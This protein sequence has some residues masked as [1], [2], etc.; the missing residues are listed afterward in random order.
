[1]V[2][3]LETRTGADAYHWHGLKRGGDRRNPYVVLQFTLEGEGAYRAGGVEQR[4]VAGSVL[5]AVVPSDHAYYLPARSGEWTFFWFITS[6]TYFVQRA[7]R[8]IERAGA[9]IEAGLHADAFKDAAGLVVDLCIGRFASPASE[10][11]WEGRLLAVMCRLDEAASAALYP[12]GPRERLLTAVRQTV[13]ADFLRPPAVEAIAEELGMSRTAFSHRF[14]LATGRTPLE[15]ITELR[16]AEVRRMLTV[17]D[18]PLKAIATATGYADANHLCK[19]F[20]RHHRMS[21]GRFRQQVR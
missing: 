3:G 12:A 2:C 8:R 20:R 5:T 17:T 14:R 9:V 1:M 6:H 16:L 11:A 7:I 19:A 13:T 10:F 21:P 4:C 15:Y 18:E